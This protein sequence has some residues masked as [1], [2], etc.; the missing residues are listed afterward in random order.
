MS[1]LNRIGR[2]Q[3]D[4]VW[5]E[6]AAGRVVRARDSRLGAAVL[7]REVF[8]PATMDPAERGRRAAAFREMAQAAARVAHP[9]VVLPS[10]LGDT[11]ES[12]YLV[13]PRPDA[14]AFSPLPEIQ[15]SLGVEELTR[16]AGEAA[17]GL[18]AL[19]AVGA[20]PPRFNPELLLRSREGTV[21]LLPLEI[22]Q[23]PV[24]SEPFPFS[25]PEGAAGEG[26]VAYSLA[27]WLYLA[28]APGA[29]PPH[30]GAARG[31][32]PEP[33]W[34]LNPSVRAAVDEALQKALHPSPAQR[35]QSLEALSRALAP[36]SAA[37]SPP[38]SRP[39]TKPEI[40]TK[41]ETASWPVYAGWAAA[42]VAGVAAGWFLSQLIPA[43]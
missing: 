8:L 35:L 39:Q 31:R 1:R 4:D 5:L 36:R 43:R 15:R 40:E 33:L 37:P 18:A 42:A 23:P 29:P 11:G 22:L 32:G 38:V 20:L 6:D 13:V 34:T 2:Y 10:D 21:K 9:V 17:A 26:A 24:E 27:A 30:E 28:L 7:I 14:G 19:A 41:N 12:L 25:A 16:V 3:V